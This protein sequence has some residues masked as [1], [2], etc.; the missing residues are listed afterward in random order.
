MIPAKEI[1]S[2]LREQADEHEGAYNDVMRRKA[3]DPNT[4]VYNGLQYEAEIGMAANRAAANALEASDALAGQVVLIR[5]SLEEIDSYSGG[6][7]TVL[8]DPYVTER[9]QAALAL[10]LHEAAA[11]VA[12][13]RQ[14][15]AFLDKLRALQ[16][17]YWEARYFDSFERA[18]TPEGSQ[19]G[20]RRIKAAED[21]QD[22]LFREYCPDYSKEQ[23]EELRK[24]GEAIRATKEAEDGK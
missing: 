5:D 9:R 17:Q 3:A 12:E 10:P 11:Q 1:V 13:W 24:W 21:A 16:I 6:A 18:G 19:E 4:K 14:K 22:A 15:A 20:G 7:D 23:Y 8:N 2:W